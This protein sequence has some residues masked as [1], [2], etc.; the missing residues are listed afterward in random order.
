MS[1]WLLVLSV[2]AK[3]DHNIRQR[4]PS[5]ALDLKSKFSHLQLIKPKES[6]KGKI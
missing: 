2:E 6:L 1:A 4:T 5:F 3:N